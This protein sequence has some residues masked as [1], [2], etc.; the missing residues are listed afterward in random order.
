M[1][2]KEFL[3][4]MKS[5]AEAWSEAKGAE[6]SGGFVETPPGK[7]T[8]R[9]QRMLLDVTDDKAK[10][11]FVQLDMVV[12]AGECEGQMIRKRTRI[13]ERN[14]IIKNGDRKGEKWEQT[15]EDCLEEI[16]RD[17]KGFSVE[18]DELEIADLPSVAD[19]LADEQPA[20]RVEVKES[21]S[22][23]L[24]VRIGKPVEDDDLPKIEDVMPE[25]NDDSDDDEDDEDEAP[26]KSKGKSSPKSKKP[27]KDEDEDDDGDEEDEEE[28]D[29]DE[30]EDEDEPG[31]DDDSDDEDE[32]DEVPDVMPPAKGETVT[33]KPKGTQ[34][35]EKHE[36]LTVNKTAQTCTLKRKRDGKTFKDVSWD[37]ID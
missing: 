26:A 27:V 6:Q 32:E 20:C 25:G 3:A 36:V 28:S 13:E 19:D 12:V 1:A 9:L 33:A 37:L 2:S 30:D 17:L 35:A 21:K 22:G 10:V 7:Y 11:P 23:Y 5:H 31:D 8:V 16:A 24:N 34:K 18:T 14:G 29:S 4:K 15:V